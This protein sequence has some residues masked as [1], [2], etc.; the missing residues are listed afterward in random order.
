MRTT[1]I[2]LTALI[3]VPA[4]DAARPSPAIGTALDVEV[5]CETAAELDARYGFR[6]EG[7]APGGRAIVL[8]ERRC[9]TLERVI[10]GWRPTGLIRLESIGIAVFVAGHELQHVAE[11]ESGIEVDENRADCLAAAGFHG[12]SERFGIGPR[13]SRRIVSWIRGIVGYRP[14]ALA[15]CF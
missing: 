6:V 1:L 8:R 10:A 13:Y 2:L 5:S 14:N 3:L 4:G 15:R 11:W 7:Y 12:T 9:R